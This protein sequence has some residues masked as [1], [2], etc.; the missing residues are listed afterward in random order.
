MAGAQA[1]TVSPMIIPLRQPQQ[2]HNSVEL[3]RRIAV[4]VSERNV[5]EDLP[6]I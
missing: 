3:S 5:S 1:C 4:A 2:L 6:V